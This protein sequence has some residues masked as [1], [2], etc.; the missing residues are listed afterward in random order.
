MPENRREQAF[1]IGARQ[2]EFV[3]VAN[4]GGLDF[5]QHF[6]FAR[7]L[8]LHGRYLQRLAG[9]DGNGGANIHGA[10]LVSIARN[11]PKPLRCL[12]STGAPEADR[13][14]PSTQQ[15]PGFRLK[16]VAEGLCAQ[17]FDF[18]A[19]FFLP[20]FL[21]AF[22]TAFLADFFAADFLAA[23][24]AFFG[25]AFLA[26]FFFFFLTAGLAAIGAGLAL[27][28]A[29]VVGSATGF[30]S[31]MWSPRV[32]R[33]RNDSRIRQCVKRMPRR[34]SGSLADL[35]T[36]PAPMRTTRGYAEEALEAVVNRYVVLYLAT[37]IVLIPID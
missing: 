18:L 31:S 6:A 12:W 22:L 25:G 17:R 4:A 33:S 32:C 3:G 19:F 13:A 2:R 24:L 1:G 34:A 9:G 28:I 29:G 5:H 7:A 23:F 14:R 21:A 30:S 37:L 16:A 15:P 27:G 26:A 10:S 11:S 8:K 35:A 20:A 36:L